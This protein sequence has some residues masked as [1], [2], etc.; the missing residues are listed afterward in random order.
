M[1]SH[2]D[3][4]LLQAL[5]CPSVRCCGHGHTNHNRCG[6]TACLGVLIKTVLLQLVVLLLYSVYDYFCRFWSG[7]Y[8]LSCCCCCCCCCCYYDDVDGDGC[9]CHYSRDDD[10]DDYY[11]LLLAGACTDSITEQHAA[12][13]SVPTR[14]EVCEPAQPNTSKCLNLGFSYFGTLT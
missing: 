1:L 3:E 5:F 6:L 9:C 14:H 12:L 11:Y 4:L 8:N 7:M 13:T 10:D 2:G